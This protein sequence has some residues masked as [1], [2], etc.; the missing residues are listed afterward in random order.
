MLEPA[1]D[2]SDCRLAVIRIGFQLLAFAKQTRSNL[3]IQ[4]G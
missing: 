3:R 4:V 2:L 1:I